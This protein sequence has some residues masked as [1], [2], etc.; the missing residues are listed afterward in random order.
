MNMTMQIKILLVAI[1]TMT[2]IFS[3]FSLAQD[4]NNTPIP[5]V[6]NYVPQ[7]TYENYGLYAAMVV[8]ATGMINTHRA[9]KISVVNAYSIEDIASDI[10][11]EEFLTESAKGT[12][13]FAFTGENETHTLSLGKDNYQSTEELLA[14]V[15]RAAIEQGYAME[16]VNMNDRSLS[17]VKILSYDRDLFGSEPTERLINWDITL[18]SSY[19]NGVSP[20]N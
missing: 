7:G 16:R 11:E 15:G 19:E 3:Q 12:F 18:S 20:Q 5:S 9:L 14:A 4:Q 2:T 10:H 17:D 8:S 6:V 13:L 1:V